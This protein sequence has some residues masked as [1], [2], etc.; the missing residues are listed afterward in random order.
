MPPTHEES[1]QF[2]RDWSK[3][4]DREQIAFRKTLKKFSEDIENLPQGEF[5]RSLR[6]K[7][8]QGVPGIFEMTWQGA[9]GRATFSYGA[10]VLEGVTH[11]TWRRIGSHVIFNDP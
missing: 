7:P 10:E 5:R 2:W 1:D 9:D 6:V 8:M 3:L 11:I 4:P